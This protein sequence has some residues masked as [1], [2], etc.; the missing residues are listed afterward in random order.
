MPKVGFFYETSTKHNKSFECLL[1]IP[2]KWKKIYMYGKI[3][4]IANKFSLSNLIDSW[5][6]DK[7]PPLQ[8]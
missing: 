4:C 8:N 1:F 6:I 2:S 5:L 3:L 7:N